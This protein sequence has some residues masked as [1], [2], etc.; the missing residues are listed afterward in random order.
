MEQKK[1]IYYILDNLSPSD[2]KLTQIPRDIDGLQNCFFNV[3]GQLEK[4]KGFEKYNTTS[5]GASHKI[6]GMHRYYQQNPLTKEFIVAW[7]T[8]WY[9]LAATDPW[10]ATA[11][12]KESGSDF[13]T[14][15]DQDTYWTDFKNRCYGVNSKGVWK[16]NAT[17]V[18]VLGITPPAAAPTGTSPGG[19]SLSTGNYKVKY[20]YVDEDGFESNASA[21]SANIACT[22]SDKIT[23][24][25][26]VSSDDKVTKRRIYRT[27]VGGSTYYYDKEVANN[28]DTSVDLTQ[29]DSTLILLT[30]LHA[31]HTVPT[32]TP[33]LVTKRRSRLVLADAENVSVSKI[34]DEYFP[35][36]NYF[37]TGNKQKITGL[38]EQ[39][40]TL[41]VYTNDSLERLTGWDSDNYEWKNAFSNEGCMAPRSLVNCKN[42]LVYLAFDGIYYYNGVTGKKLDYKLSE[43]IMDN[44]NPTYMDLSCGTYFEDKYLLTYPKGASTVPNETVYYDFK[45]Q[46]AG[47]FD[48]GFS[49]YSVWD[50][51]GDTYSLKGGSNTEG[52]VYKV[53]SGLDDDGANIPCQD[54]TLPLDFGKPDIWKNYYNIYIKVKTTTG[55]ALTMYYTIDDDNE[56][57]C[58]SQ[59]LTANKTLWYK[60]DMGSGGNRGRAIAIRP[61]FTDKYA[62]TT[63]GYMIVYQEED[64]EWS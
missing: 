21:A 61:Y 24:A 34:T 44:I 25:I 39:L 18:R 32:S 36:E 46:T 42:L 64:A 50:K 7:N 13:T 49:C 30:Q 41:S 43:Y 58:T 38:K 15:A 9:G 19:G 52:R 33:H 17:Y 8:K 62:R 37:P 59:T 16:Y 60:F 22:A 55:T 56:T 26:V 28:V 14:T 6:T 5:I 10:G 29:A 11:L 48:F 31:D 53:F 20:T 54:K 23:L 51:G 45:T 57:S 4:R 27:S 3:D 47:I 1:K 35:A 12:E 63:M 40:T 2:V